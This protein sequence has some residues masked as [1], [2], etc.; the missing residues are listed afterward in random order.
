MSISMASL[1]M[2]DEQVPVSARDALKAAHDAS[3]GDRPE[4]LR[5]AARILFAE[6]DLDCADVREL[7]D[8]PPD[9]CCR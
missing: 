5:S 8:L 2:H 1:L 9:G 6:T 7:V 3:E 4:S